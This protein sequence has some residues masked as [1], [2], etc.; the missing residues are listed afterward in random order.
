MTAYAKT[1]ADT[2]TAIRFLIAPWLVWLGVTGGQDT[3]PTATVALILAWAT[4][5]LDGP[6]ARRDPSQRQTWIGNH[7]LQVDETVAFGV[8][9]YLAATGFLSLPVSLGYLIVAGL[10][11]WLFRSAHLAW[12]LQAPPYGKMLLVA[13]QEAPAY[14]AMAVGW[15]ALTVVATWP[16]FP[17]ETVPQFIGGIRDLLRNLNQE[18]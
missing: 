18:R 12:G 3:L 7:D 13:L 15:I 9:I 1:L 5:M 10:L 4:D 14:G 11:L 16:R 2:L 17:R 6:L 8:L